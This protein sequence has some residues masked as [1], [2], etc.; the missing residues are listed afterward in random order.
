MSN[1]E[2]KRK[3]HISC[4]IILAVGLCAAILIHEFAEDIPDASLGDT[5]VN[6]T[7]Y[8]LSTRDSKKYRHDLERFGGKA[9]LVFDDFYQWLSQLLQGKRL[10]KT[11][12]WISVLVSLGVY[13]FARSLPDAKDVN[14][15][16]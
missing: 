15:S 13:L 12:A 2:L 7:L 8:P 11:V 14:K 6:G 9:A 4:L 16:D 1:T 10:G 3:L 5:V